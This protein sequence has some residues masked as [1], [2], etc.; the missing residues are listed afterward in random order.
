MKLVG[1]FHGSPSLC[2]FPDG[3][4]ACT[5]GGGDYAASVRVA[6]QEL[7]SKGSAPADRQSDGTETLTSE[8]G[9]LCQRTEVE[10]DISGKK[11]NC[12]SEAAGEQSANPRSLCTVSEHLTPVSPTSPSP[13]SSVPS[14]TEAS[15]AS[16]NAC[17]VQPEVASSS[18]QEQTIS[19]AEGPSRAP[20]DSKSPTFAGNS[21]ARDLTL[22]SSASTPR[23][24]QL[25]VIADE[26]SSHGELRDI[27]TQTN[28]P[29]VRTQQRDCGKRVGFSNDASIRQKDSGKGVRRP[30]LSLSEWMT[31]LQ[32][33][34]ADAVRVNSVV[35]EFERRKVRPESNKQKSAEGSRCGSATCPT[36]PATGGVGKGDPVATEDLDLHLLAGDVARQRWI[37]DR[38]P[39]RSETAQGYAEDD[40]K[41]KRLLTDAV[42]I[43]CIMNGVSYWQGM[44]DLCAAFL[45]LSP[46]PSL[47]QL[48]LLFEA[49]V[50]LFA[51]W[52]LLPPQQ[53]LEHSANVTRLFRQL[54]QFFSPAV[55]SEVERL[56]PSVTWSQTTLIHTLGF[57][58]FRDPRT[59]LAIWRCILELRAPDDAT[60][61]GYFFFLLAYADL[62]KEELRKY[63]EIIINS[64]VS[65]DHSCFSREPCP[66]CH[67]EEIPSST[68]AISQLDDS[69][70]LPTWQ[71]SFPLRRVLHCMFK[72]Y[73]L[74]PP[75]A[76]QDLQ[77]LIVTCSSLARSGLRDSLPRHLSR[78][79]PVSPV[80]QQEQ[81]AK[82]T[83]Q[84][85]SASSS[86]PSSLAMS[87]EMRAA[88][89]TSAKAK[90]DLMSL[91]NSLC[92]SLDPL[93]LL[94]ELHTPLRCRQ[95]A[96]DSVSRHLVS[97]TSI[98][99]DSSSNDD[100]FYGLLALI[101]GAM[102]SRRA[103]NSTSRSGI[104][105]APAEG[106]A[107]QTSASCEEDSISSNVDLASHSREARDGATCPMS[108][109]PL[110]RSRVLEKRGTAG[111][112]PI[113]DTSAASA[114]ISDSVEVHF[115]DLRSA[116]Q[117]QCGPAVQTL[118]GLGPD[119][120]PGG[121]RYRVIPVRTQRGLR[122]A[123][124]NCSIN[125]KDSQAGRRSLTV[126]WGR[127]PSSGPTPSTLE[128]GSSSLCQHQASEPA[129]FDNMH[130]MRRS[131]LP[132][133]IA[134]DA[135]KSCPTSAGLR[136]RIA[137][138]PCE[139]Q[140]SLKN[141]VSVQQ[142]RGVAVEG[143]GVWLMRRRRH[144]KGVVREKNV[145]SVSRNKLVQTTTPLGTHDREEGGHNSISLDNLIDDIHE[146][147]TT[148]PEVM[149][150]WILIPDGTQI[151]EELLDFGLLYPNV[152]WS[153]MSV[154]QEAYVRLTSAAVRGVL[155]LNGGF[156]ALKG[157]IQRLQPS[158]RD[159]LTPRPVSSA[160]LQ[161]VELL[162]QRGS[163]RDGTADLPLLA[164]TSDPAG[165]HTAVNLR[166]TVAHLPEDL[167]L[168]SGVCTRKEYILTLQQIPRLQ[169]RR[170]K[171]R[172]PDLPVKVSADSETPA[173]GTP[174]SAMRGVGQ[175]I[176]TWLFDRGE[177][178]K[179]ANSH[180]A[181]NSHYQNGQLLPSG[182][183]PTKGQVPT[184]ANKDIQKHQRM[185]F[186]M[187]SPV[188]WSQC[189]PSIAGAALVER[190]PVAEETARYCPVSGTASGP[191]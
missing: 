70:E 67:E 20:S 65:F 128:A 180:N 125:A 123:V 72:L 159:R 59:L 139:V 89:D 87:S 94:T 153:E 97:P 154:L 126:G 147:E 22:C 46:T 25:P 69:S 54:L 47:P 95:D 55:T 120:L 85:F 161:A 152:P 156:S 8:D 44:H 142:S 112:C 184:P 163:T 43:F 99:L 102:S 151:N 164:A 172:S 171:V 141:Y 105:E 136:K 5:R 106:G 117:R 74:T 78:I 111:A 91:Q 82:E 114:W 76:L 146:T 181:S 1:D 131:A 26:P 149:R 130:V 103:R 144:R 42:S 122:K 90:M 11:C 34:R 57:S 158:L 39:P 121:A 104:P 187:S 73:S 35:D 18:L 134:G 176:A 110:A 174:T 53:S 63:P 168:R 7:P 15:S 129:A 24:S 49:F 77:A 38:N 160:A 80:R 133:I 115:L 118:L 14:N 127:L 96:F 45:F 48:V 12:S 60:P 10:L 170:R 169:R 41:I 51:P 17:P 19:A 30:G 124:D 119:R 36:S 66:A 190:P 132:Q 75:T 2:D 4:H 56:I 167:E 189:A 137:Q 32:V 179:R 9:R 88:T 92:L 40:V 79:S 81:F 175:A 61:L 178:V 23:R 165:V 138:G 177:P 183:V 29:S 37:N 71:R 58:R 21:C 150:I 28:D 191:H 27:L 148:T 100:A 145:Q 186:L 107:S 83:A 113:V 108:K 185:S 86:D 16:A 52:L 68:S 3:G 157:A 166:E 135:G 93:D 162:E 173:P 98:T 50:M 31:L 188:S 140:G 182:Q 109:G 143:S 13:L 116:S 84:F 62:H 101:R 33:S 6:A 155:L 64:D